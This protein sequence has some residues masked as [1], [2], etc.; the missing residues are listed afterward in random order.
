MTQHHIAAFF[1]AFAALM[2]LDGIV[3]TCLK[4]K[5]NMT[6]FAVALVCGL[7]FAALYHP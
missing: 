1:A 5:V 3:I 6:P 2:L 4:R 7:V